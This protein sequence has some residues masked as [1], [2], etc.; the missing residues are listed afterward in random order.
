MYLLGDGAFVVEG[1]LLG[2]DGE[3]PVD[4]L[5]GD[6]DL[7]VGVPLV[8]VEVFDLEDGFGEDGPLEVLGLVAPVV[9]GVG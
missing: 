8:E 3:V 2:V 1:D 4:A 6:V 7:A 5:L 9:Y